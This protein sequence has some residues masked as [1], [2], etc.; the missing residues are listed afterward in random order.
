[1]AFGSG[2]CLGPIAESVTTL[3]I[4]LNFQSGIPRLGGG[5][6]NGLI[7]FLYFRI[8]FM[9]TAQYNCIYR[10]VVNLQAAPQKKGA[11]CTSRKLVT[12]TLVTVVVVLPS[13]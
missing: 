3:S 5:G 8:M 11:A 6:N 9:F 13:W 1:M 12:G 7:G 10:C 4:F 2:W